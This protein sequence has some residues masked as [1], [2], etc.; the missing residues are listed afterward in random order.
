MSL[1]LCLVWEAHILL[2]VCILGDLQ[3]N[4]HSES[5]SSNFKNGKIKRQQIGISSLPEKLYYAKLDE[6][7][8]IDID[9]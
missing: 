6:F 8:S 3:R 5:K 7:I 2:W 1:S 9:C 4:V